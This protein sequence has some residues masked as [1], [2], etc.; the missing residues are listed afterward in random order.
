MTFYR[1]NRSGNGAYYSTSHSNYDEA[2]DFYNK[3][4][5]TV[6][7]TELQGAEGIIKTCRKQ[8]KDGKYILVE[9]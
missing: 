5:G 4:K 1:V 7:Y 8:Y 6:K 3:V 2:L 9:N